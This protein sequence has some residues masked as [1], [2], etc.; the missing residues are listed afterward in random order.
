[1]WD[2]ARGCIRTYTAL[3]EKARHFDSLPEVQE[4][5]AA[6]STPEL[7]EASAAGLGETDALKAQAGEL[8]VLADR[9][10]HNEALD[11]LVVDVLLGLR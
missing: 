4:A 7:G 9:G 6:A 11:Q 10:Y 5:L 8:D 2:F 3:A 1:M